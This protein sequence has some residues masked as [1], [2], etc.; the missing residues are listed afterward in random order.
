VRFEDV[1]AGSARGRSAHLEYEEVHRVVQI[2]QSTF[3]CLAHP[4]ISLLHIS[5][6]HLLPL[7][8]CRR[9]I[10]SLKARCID[11]PSESDVGN[12]TWHMVIVASSY[13]GMHACEPTLLETSASFE[14]MVGR[15]TR[16][17]VRVIYDA[18]P[19]LAYGTRFRSLHATVRRTKQNYQIIEGNNLLSGSS[20]S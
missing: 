19:T 6:P 7:S 9:T 3:S 17:S 16:G 5:F 10:R 12:V 18:L 20:V 2:G 1:L 13:V 15:E 11:L 14:F 8:S 4:V